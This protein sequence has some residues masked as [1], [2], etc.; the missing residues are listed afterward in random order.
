MALLHDHKTDG[1]H[2]PAHM[3]YQMSPWLLHKYAYFPYSCPI[4]GDIAFVIPIILK[5]LEVGNQKCFLPL[6]YLA[7]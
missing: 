5:T 7:L 3:K 4:F 2:Y 1:P 6:F